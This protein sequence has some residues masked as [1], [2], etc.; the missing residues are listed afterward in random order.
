MNG[1][2]F[3]TCYASLQVR[4]ATQGEINYKSR[5][6]TARQRL[7]SWFRCI[8]SIEPSPVVDQLI[9]MGPMK[10]EPVDDESL[11]RKSK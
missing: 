4:A 6:S 5:S 9:E 3:I 2:S 8:D 1:L 11:D 7:K 10:K